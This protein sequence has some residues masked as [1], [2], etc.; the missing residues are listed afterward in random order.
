MWRC[1]AARRARSYP[2]DRP[3]DRRFLAEPTVLAYRHANENKRA[4]QRHPRPA[5]PR[6]VVVPPTPLQRRR[7]VCA[8][9]KASRRRWCCSGRL[10][11][12]LQFHWRSLITMTRPHGDWPLRRDSLLAE[13]QAQNQELRLPRSRVRNA[14]V[15]ERVLRVALQ[16]NSPAKPQLGTRSVTPGCQGGGSVSAI[17]SRVVASN[18]L[19]SAGSDRSNSPCD[20]TPIRTIARISGSFMIHL[21]GARRAGDIRTE[22]QALSACPNIRSQ[23]R[24]VS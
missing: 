3:C 20:N 17:S 16:S 7:S 1:A 19:C 23:I 2:R 14:R 9:S 15:N 13:C 24:T 4:P 12:C 5:R 11:H 18:W 22:Y 8:C 6:R 21:P 10:A